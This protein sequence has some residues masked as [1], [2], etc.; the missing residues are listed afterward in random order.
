MEAPDRLLAMNAAH[1]AFRRD[2]DRLATAAGRADLADPRRRAALLAGWRTFKTQMRKHHQG[3]DDH[4]WPRLRE[5]L[6]GSENALSVLAEMDAEHARLDTLLKAVDDTLET[7]GQNGVT[8]GS[9]PAGRAE[10]EGAVRELHEA[11]SAHLGHEERDALPLI[12]MALSDA[13]WDDVMD[14]IRASA[15]LAFVAEYLPW[16]ADGATGEEL[17]RIETIVPPPFRAVYRQEWR[18]DYARTDRW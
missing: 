9:A 10:V 16:L 11:L 8:G 18:P 14:A 5:R 6:S 12:G 17:E 1:A 3:E 15:D 2:L 4:I 13:E 7:P